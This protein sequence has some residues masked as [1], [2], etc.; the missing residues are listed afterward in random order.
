VEQGVTVAIYS[1]K[2]SKATTTAAGTTT[3]TATAV[4]DSRYTTLVRND[5]KTLYTWWTHR[6][7]I[8]C[9]KYG[10]FSTQLAAPTF[11]MFGLVGDTIVGGQAALHYRR[12]LPTMGIT[13]QGAYF[14][15]ATGAPIK[16]TNHEGMGQTQTTTSYTVGPPDK[17]LFAV[18]PEC[19]KA[20]TEQWTSESSRTIEASRM[21][22]EPTPAFSH[23]RLVPEGLED[24]VRT[25]LSSSHRPL[26]GATPW[27][28]VAAGVGT[29]PASIDW[30]AAGKVTSARDQV[31]AA[32]LLEL[33]SLEFCMG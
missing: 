18:P 20:T 26:F 1:S 22:N 31:C 19:A 30:R 33:E 12:S 21:F 14:D 24:A 4:T 7:A 3:S 13:M 16:I 23:R 5:L 28:E 9:L 6:G 27:S 11:P 17:S 8:T 25:K 15:A 2:D 10:N 32:F 29:A